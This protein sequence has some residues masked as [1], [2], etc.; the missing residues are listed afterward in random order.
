VDCVQSA[1]ELERLTVDEQLEPI[2]R[3]VYLLR[4]VDIHLNSYTLV[5][6]SS[7]SATRGVPSILPRWEISVGNPLSI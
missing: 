2:E 3:A 4:S 7:T 1:E 6:C 5:G